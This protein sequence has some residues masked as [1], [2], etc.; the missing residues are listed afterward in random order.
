MARRLYVLCVALI[1]VGVLAA[2]GAEPQAQ[3]F[4]LQIRQ[5]QLV[6]HQGPIRVKQG[7]AVTLRW[8]IDETVKLH[9][10]RYDI[11]QVG[12]PEKPAVFAFKAY[13]S[14]RFPITAHGFGA[15]GHGS[16]HAETVL[17][18]LEVLPP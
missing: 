13:A 18:Y 3:T 11:E 10:H 17:V 6:E 1:C 15:P 5:C 2:L 16:G 4:D 14:S 12:K 7:D 8:R 9:L